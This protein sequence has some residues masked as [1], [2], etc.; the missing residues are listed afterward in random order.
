MK[1]DS[2]K[3]SVFYIFTVLIATLSQS[4]FAVS[5]DLRGEYETWKSG[6]GGTSK[7]FLAGVG[8]TQKLN[9]Q[10]AIGGGFVM[11]NYGTDSIAD[12]DVKRL[13]IDITLSYRYKPF[14]TLFLGYQNIRLNVDNETDATRSFDDVAHGLGAGVASYLPLSKNWFLQGG[15]GVDSLYATSEMPSVTES[16]FGYSASV[17]GGVLYSITK[18]M[19]LGLGLKSRY[20]AV[21]YSGDEGKWSHNATR[22]LLSLSHEI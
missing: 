9:K 22:I 14:V 6:L 10:F 7:A 5:V 21:N 17:N 19:T 16:G 1:S 4:V 15:F 2:F 20:S 12:K 3:K 11:G 8:A 18:K 13:D